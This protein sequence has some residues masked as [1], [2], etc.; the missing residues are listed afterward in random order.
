MVGRIASGLDVI[1]SH[2]GHGI[3]LGLVAETCFTCDGDNS[4]MSSKLGLNQ[5]GIVRRLTCSDRMND[6]NVHSSAL[7]DA[8]DSYAYCGAHDWSSGC[9][10]RT[11]LN[12]RHEDGFVKYSNI[13]LARANNWAKNAS[14]TTHKT[15]DEMLE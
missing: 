14:M 3:V 6:W 4:I 9:V 10:R 12:C 1:L 13:K 15:Q 7:G 8:C 2:Q 5:D 11:P